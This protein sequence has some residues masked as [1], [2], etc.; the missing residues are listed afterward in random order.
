MQLQTSSI[1]DTS[2]RLTPD[3]ATREIEIGP[4]DPRNNVGWGAS[5]TRMVP[6]N[7]KCSCFPP[8]PFLFFC[9]LLPRQLF[10][11]RCPTLNAPRPLAL[12]YRL[13]LSIKPKSVIR[14]FCEYHCLLSAFFAAFSLDI[15]RY[16]FEKSHQKPLVTRTE[17]MTDLG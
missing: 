2:H 5:L 6:I 12:G 1:I 3:R 4:G 16:A 9:V 11:W 8:P 14:P 17:I 15:A 10:V 13:A 7:P